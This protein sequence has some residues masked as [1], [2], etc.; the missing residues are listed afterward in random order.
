MRFIYFLQ[1]SI[2]LFSFTT[3][4]GQIAKQANQIDSIQSAKEIEALLS[5][6]DERLKIFKVMSDLKFPDKS[7]QKTADSLK[8]SP[9]AKADFDNNG[10]TD[11][12]VIGC[13]G[14]EFLAVCILDEG[15]NKYNLIFLTRRAFE[16]CSFPLVRTD[17]GS[18]KIEY[19]YFSYLTDKNEPF[20]QHL[21][22]K[23]L[24]Y[25]FGDFIEDT[26][27]QGNH[28][29]QKI[30][31][32]TSGCFGRCAVFDL[33]ISPNRAALWGAERYNQIKN[34]VFSGTFKT[35][36]D[37]SRYK[38][39]IDLVNYIDFEKL[40][41]N[42]EISWSDDQTAIITITYDDGKTKT[43]RDYG[44]FGTFGLNRLYNLLFDL[45]ENQRWIKTNT[46]NILRKQETIQKMYP[47]IPRPD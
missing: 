42:Y 22:K 41:Q 3:S 24:V 18:V 14:H 40:D 20:T 12:L 23:T 43:I 9:W 13:N 6:T 17:D 33:E 11:L 35:T 1:F 7:C 36:L 34:K 47:S 2:A 39:I 46:S 32:S 21:L 16:D 30:E 15:N 27:N 5:K 8:I 4:N 44:L 29:I 10:L 31:Y 45:R 38:Q 19:F 28:S 37:S 26:N 25:K